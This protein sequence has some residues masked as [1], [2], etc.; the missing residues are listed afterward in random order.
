MRASGFSSRNSSAA[1]CV[2]GC[3]VLEPSMVM[4]LETSSPPPP[5]PCAPLA[6]PPHAASTS[7]NTSRSPTPAST[8]KRPVILNPYTPLART[9]QHIGLLPA[10]DDRA[11]ISALRYTRVR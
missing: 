10:P 1:A 9:A 7:D 4:L 11:R 6:P 5:P 2:I 8:L 3:T